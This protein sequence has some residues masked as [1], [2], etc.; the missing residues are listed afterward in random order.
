MDRD[1]VL[2]LRESAAPPRPRMPLAR[3][4]E[5]LLTRTPRAT[6]EAVEITRN[7]KGDYQYNVS[8]VAQEGETLEDCCIR[9]QAVA[10]KLA[11]AYAL[12]R[13]QLVAQQGDKLIESARKAV[14]EGRA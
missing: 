5:L 3:V 11:E 2:A 10:D 12:S 1:E 7:A 6:Q 8:A 14:K 9:A 4:V 13:A